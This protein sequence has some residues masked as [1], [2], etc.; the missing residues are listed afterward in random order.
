MCCAGRCQQRE[1]LYFHTWESWITSGFQG[2][3]QVHH[4]Q[5]LFYSRLNDTLTVIKLTCTSWVLTVV[6]YN[7]ISWGQWREIMELS[8]AWRILPGGCGMGGWDIWGV[9]NIVNGLRPPKEKMPRMRVLRFLRQGLL[10]HLRT[11]AREMVELPMSFSSLVFSILNPAGAQG[12]TTA[13]G[14]YRHQNRSQ[15]PSGN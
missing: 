9:Q 7:K 5:L 6:R 13:C 1:I 15:N 10:K 2:N 11:C 12:D 4:F 14:G 3:V 8:R